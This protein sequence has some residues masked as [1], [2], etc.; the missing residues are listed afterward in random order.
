MQYSYL[1]ETSQTICSA[2][3]LIG[4]C[5]I[6]VLTLHGT[7]HF[8][9]GVGLSINSD[10]RWVYR[11]V[12]IKVT[13]LSSFAVSQCIARINKQIN[14][15]LNFLYLLLVLL[16]KIKKSKLLKKKMGMLHPKGRVHALA[17]G[18]LFI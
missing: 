11:N 16:K 4:V 10:Q 9:S 18:F 13:F 17:S 3:Q 6:E 1:I 12:L 14:L 7:T 15:C 8:G 5:M 2:N